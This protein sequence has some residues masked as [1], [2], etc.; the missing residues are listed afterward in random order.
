MAGADRFTGRGL[1]I[2]HAPQHP[3]YKYF[4][5]TGEEQYESLMA[6]PLIVRGVTVGVILIQTREPRRF[7]RH[8]VEALGLEGE[9]SH[10][11][12]IPICEIIGCSIRKQIIFYRS[13]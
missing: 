6:A 1:V 9:A 8:E 12:H 7:D 2:E 11:A 4:P 10:R 3:S 5:E 13:E